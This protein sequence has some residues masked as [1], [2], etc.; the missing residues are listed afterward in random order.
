MVA[1]KLFWSER[2]MDK[3]RRWF[4]RAVTVDPDLGD[5]WAYLYKFEM[6]H[7]NEEQQQ[8]LV[9][10]CVAADPRHGEAWTKVSK[11]IGNIRLKTEEI[12]PL[13]A[14]LLPNPYNQ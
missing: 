5:A 12:L 2:N 11:D 7:G 3:A 4:N 6:K 13:V 10:R 8:D 9:K 14:A 1:A